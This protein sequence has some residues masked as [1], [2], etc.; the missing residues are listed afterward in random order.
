[1]DKARLNLTVKTLTYIIKR[2]LNFIMKPEIMAANL[3]EIAHFNKEKTDILVKFWMAKTKDMLE[4]VSAN[5]E[6]IDV[7]WELKTELASAAEQKSRTALGVLRMQ[8]ADKNELKLELSHL[9]LSE[10]Y[11]TLEGV[12]EELDILRDSQR[13]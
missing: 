9:E 6:L 8:T 2:A 13:T 4:G 10:L 5:S 7:Q 12:Q 1:M 3:M 11:A